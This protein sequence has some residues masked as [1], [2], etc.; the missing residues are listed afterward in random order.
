M[1]YRQEIA[2]LRETLK[3]HKC[4]MLPQE[5]ITLDI[6]RCFGAVPIPQ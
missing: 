5:L 2:Q 6:E 1:D 3:M 4:S